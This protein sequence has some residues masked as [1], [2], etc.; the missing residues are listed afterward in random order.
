MTLIELIEEVHEKTHVDRVEI[1]SR[2]TSA[3][4]GKDF[5]TPTQCNLLVRS[6][7]GTTPSL[8]SSLGRV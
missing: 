8:A 3:W 4:P 5:F 2:A 1:F 6:L 7:R